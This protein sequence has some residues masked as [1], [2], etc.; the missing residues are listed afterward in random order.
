MSS[1]DLVFPDNPTVI[2]TGE[3]S[4]ITMRSAVLHGT[5]NPDY[6]KPGDKIGFVFSKRANPSKKDG[7]VLIAEDLDQNYSF[8]V[9][10]TGLDYAGVYYYY[11]FLNDD[12][13]GEVLSFKT[14]D[15]S[16]GAVDMGLSVKWGSANLGARF[17]QDEGDYY[18]WGEI[19]P[20]DYYGWDNYRFYQG[21]N[22][23]MIIT[24]YNDERTANGVVPVDNK[25]VLD[26]EDDAAYALLGGNW[27]I[28]T[29][30]E[31]DELLATIDNPHYVWEWY[32]EMNGWKVTFLDNENSIFLPVNAEKIEEYVQKPGFV[33][34]WSSTVYEG[35]PY[36]AYYCQICVGYK[37]ED[38]KIKTYP[39]GWT[40]TTSRDFGYPIRPVCDETP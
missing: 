2:T 35:H 5:V 10:M 27:R 13:Q 37:K 14:L 19:V 3:A 7:Y 25:Q 32:Q 8:S 12:Y 31:L 34:I 28:P 38:G 1:C 4:N 11:A 21:P 6:W 9:T 18:A 40:H 20:K 29:V 39:Y 15:Y 36:S 23:E 22:D 33:W 17:P 24:K 26:K 16:F 30:Q